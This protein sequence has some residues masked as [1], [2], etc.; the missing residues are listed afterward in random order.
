MAQTITLDQLSGHNAREDLWIAVHGK[1][2]DLT[3]FAEDHPGGIE[4]LKECAGT[5]ATESYDYV[6]H[7]R[8][9]TRKMQ[10][11]LVGNLEGVGEVAEPIAVT[12]PPGQPRPGAYKTPAI[13]SNSLLKII[14]TLLVV[15]VAGV[16]LLLR[17]SVFW[18]SGEGNATGRRIGVEGCGYPMNIL[19]YALAL[20]TLLSGA[21]VA[22]IYSEFEKTLH[23]KEVFSYPSVIPRKSR[24]R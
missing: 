10:Q 8:G 3:T 9:A 16:L 15:A 1:V 12:I 24:K 21:G 17:R 11:Y 4:V 7:T 22:Y 5:D 13:K 18:G 20:I 14:T 2:Y 23:E 6:G 19:F